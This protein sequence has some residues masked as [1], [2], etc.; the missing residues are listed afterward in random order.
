MNSASHLVRDAR[1]SAGLTQAQ[2]AARLGRTQPT[3]AAL[4]RPGSNPRI[5]TL[6]RALRATGH[7]LLSAS[8]PLAGIDETQIIERLQL[9]PGARLRTFHTSQAK[10]AD[11]VRTAHRV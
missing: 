3:I 6:E 9:A 2:L 11:L 1:R 5:A 10:L 7:E 4:E 8:R